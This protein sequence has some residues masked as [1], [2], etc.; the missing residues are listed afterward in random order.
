[1]AG[2]PSAPDDELDR[3]LA[4]VIAAEAQNRN[5]WYFGTER[6][7]P[8]RTNKRFL[9][10]MIRSA[11]SHNQ[12]Q[13]QAQARERRAP[14]RPRCR[15]ERRVEFCRAVELHERRGSS[16][17]SKPDA[18]AP[19]SGHSRLRRSQ[20]PPHHRAPA[21]SRRRSPSPDAPIGPRPAREWDRG[22]GLYF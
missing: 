7:R 21:P 10:S 9:A 3:Y 2:A 14:S 17:K 18:T 4:D 20:S 6:L 11:D 16:T 19:P 8:T 22:K 5:A 12:R 1:M 13:E 15:S